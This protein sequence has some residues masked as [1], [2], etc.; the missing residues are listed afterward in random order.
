[1]MIPLVLSLTRLVDAGRILDNARLTVARTL[2]A[3]VPILLET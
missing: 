3:P 1:M 2:A